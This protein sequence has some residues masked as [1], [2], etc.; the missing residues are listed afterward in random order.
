MNSRGV[1]LPEG[2][3][4]DDAEIETVY[5][6]GHRKN[7]IFRKIIEKEG[8]QVYEDAFTMLEKWRKENVKLAIISSSRNCRHIIE[9]AGIAELFDSRV[10]GE[11][12]AEQDLPGKPA[13]DIFLKAC[14]SL[15]V[16]PEETIILED[17]I[18]GIEAGKKG[19]FAKVIGVARHGDENELKAAG[20]DIIVKELTE[21]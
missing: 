16:R 17:S 11:I 5:G 2:E 7:D 6:L 1:Q 3:Y 14:E 8:A 21:L 19:G 18:A 10:D 4:G 20:A 9:S 12:M 13:P 15:G